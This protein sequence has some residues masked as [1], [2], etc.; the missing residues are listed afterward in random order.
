MRVS[1]L[2]PRSRADLSPIRYANLAPVA[3]I[4]ATLNAAIVH[5]PPAAAPMEVEADGEESE[6]EPELEPVRARPIPIP[7]ARPMPIPLVPSTP[8]SQIAL[9]QITPS[10]TP[11]LYTWRRPSVSISTSP[12]GGPLTNPSARRSLAHIAPAGAALRA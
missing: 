1:P 10:A 11:R 9:P 3:P 4:P 12:V 7:R 2:T 5:A 6:S 8:P